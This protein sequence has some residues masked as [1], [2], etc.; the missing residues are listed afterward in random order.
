MC[1][2]A[3]VRGGSLS[4]IHFWKERRGNKVKKVGVGREGEGGGIKIRVGRVVRKEGSERGEGKAMRVTA[5]RVGEEAVDSIVAGLCNSTKVFIDGA[6]GEGG[7]EKQGKDGE[8]GG[9][10]EI[11]ESSRDGVRQMEGKRVGNSGEL[12]VVK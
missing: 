5:G 12:F 4:D 1:I 8:G 11:D 3:M 10:D 2:E 6:F 7:G 9:V